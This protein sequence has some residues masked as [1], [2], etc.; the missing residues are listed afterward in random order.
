MSKSVKTFSSSVGAW[1]CRAGLNSSMPE[2]HPTPCDRYTDFTVQSLWSAPSIRPKTQRKYLWKSNLSCLGWKLLYLW[3]ETF[4]NII[5]GY[6]HVLFL[7]TRQLNYLCLIELV[8]CVWGHALHT[9]T[10]VEQL[11][12][13]FISLLKDWTVLLGTERSPWACEKR[14]TTPLNKQAKVLGTKKKSMLLD[15]PHKLS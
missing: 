3:L 4:Q 11:S 14:K 1:Q 6:K 8:C 15:S 13:H 12:Y 7:I 2:N 9:E 5:S 10:N